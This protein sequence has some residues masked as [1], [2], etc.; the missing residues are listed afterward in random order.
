VFW[1]RRGLKWHSYDPTPEVKSVEE[2][3]SLVGED[4]SEFPHVIVYKG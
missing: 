3:A 4:A 1:Q 2:F